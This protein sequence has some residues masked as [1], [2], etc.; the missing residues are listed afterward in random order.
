MTGGWPYTC[1]TFLMEY[2]PYYTVKWKDHNASDQHE[3]TD[4][5][6]YLCPIVRLIFTC[7]QNGRQ[8]KE[9]SY[10][11]WNVKS[12]MTIRIDRQVQ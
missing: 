12:L 8:P 1:F 3:T 7:D 9:Y 4:L 2:S 6:G 11:K 5:V 10:Y